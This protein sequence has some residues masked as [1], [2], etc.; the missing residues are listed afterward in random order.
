[1]SS[2]I[3]PTYDEVRTLPTLHEGEVEPEFIDANG[4]MNIRHY[5]DA[6]ALGADVLCRRI[7]ID[8][9]YRSERRL[10]VFTVEH[11][12]RYFAEMRE[13]S[14]FT[15]HTVLVDRSSRATHMM[16]L[17]LDRTEARLACT[18]ELMLVSVGMD[19]RRPADFPDDIAVGMDRWIADSQRIAW[20]IPLSGSMWIR[21]A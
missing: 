5:L 9:G 11:H 6:G 7:G 18:V 15:V 2:N 21:R 13:A 12:I 4:H 20:P 1:M 19:S 3:S 17:I 8:D 16:S 14:R 10:G